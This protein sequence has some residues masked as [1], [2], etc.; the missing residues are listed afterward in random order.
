MTVFKISYTACA[1]GWIK[2]MSNLVSDFVEYIVILAF[3]YSYT[4]QEDRRMVAILSDHFPCHSDSML[5]PGIIADMLPARYFGEYQ[6]SDFI[7]G[8]NEMLRLR[9]M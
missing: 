1:S 9:I 6:Q 5:L 2:F 8:I 4:P 7:A 3:I